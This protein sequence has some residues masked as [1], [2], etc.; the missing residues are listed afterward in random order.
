MSREMSMKIAFCSSE[1][2]PFAKTG[3]L[4]DVCGALPLA[5]E[6]LGHEVV[7]FLPK[8]RSID[9]KKHGLHK[10]QVILPWSLHGKGIKV[11]FIDNKK[12]FDREGLY[13][14]A[15]A[16]YPDNLDRFSFFCAKVL[17]GMK[18]LNYKPDIIH[19]HDWQT[20][21][22]P[23]YLQ[24]KSRKDIFYRGI[25]T[26]FTIHN[27]AFQGIFSKE[28]YP[29]LRLRDD[30]FHHQR[31]EYYGKINLLKSAI[32][33][34]DEIST[35]SEQYAKEIQTK[36]L[37]AGLDKVLLSRKEEISGIVNGIDHE[38]WDPAKDGF[39]VQKY[40]SRDFGAGKVVNKMALKRELNFSNDK[41]YPLFGFVA[42]LSHQKGLDL[43]IRALED[44][45]R[46]DIGIVI[47]GV[48]EAT[49]YERLKK[50][51]VKYPDQ[52]ALCFEF[53]EKLAHQIYA[54][55]DFFLMPSTFEPC[56]LSQLIAL[57]YGTIPIVFKTGGLVDT[58]QPFDESTLEGHGF[59]FETYQPKAFVQKVQHALNIYGG[60]KKFGKLV[61]NAFKVDFS[62]EKSAKKYQSVYAKLI[63][64]EI[65][66]I[67]N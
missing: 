52:L 20:A 4:A 55:C 56:G 40:S 61:K 22:I 21:L 41:E 17:S 60:K 53:N 62:W 43:I 27:L 36:Q 25:K 48:G 67:N 18:A 6:E 51:A 33:Y 38:I 15:H 19:C 63:S 28:Q 44:L 11:F 24:E 13:G 65:H 7:I 5:L 14:T 29:K 46:L 58:I 49:Y 45:M 8:Y 64:K 9:E 32:I 34:A 12:Y 37:G 57:R 59:V 16:D 54:G 1:V 3:G 42:R 66:M 30:L 39:I 50:F 26:L 2:V 23:I 35:V 31:L 10:T 47:Q